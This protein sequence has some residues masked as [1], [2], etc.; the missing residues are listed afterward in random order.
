MKWLY[1]E[2]GR[3]FIDRWSAIHFASGVVIGANLE[4]FAL[5]IWLR[6]VVC[7]VLAYTW[8]VIELQLQLHTDIVKHPESK[9]NR[10]VSDPIMMILGAALG[11]WLVHGQ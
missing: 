6:L 4:A 10:W 8:E 7:L 11:G 9:L 5:A 3:S 1:G 2:T